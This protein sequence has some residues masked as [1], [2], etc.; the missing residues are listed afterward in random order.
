MDMC[1]KAMKEFNVVFTKAD[2]V[3]DPYK[4]QDLYS[5]AE[6]FLRKYKFYSPWVFITSVK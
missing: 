4:A 5:K 3:R 1:R 2:K 6:E